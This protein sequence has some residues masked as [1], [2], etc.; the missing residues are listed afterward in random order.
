MGRKKAPELYC[1]HC[2]QCHG[3]Q[4][5]AAL[6]PSLTDAIWSLGNPTTLDLSKVIREGSPNKAMPAWGQI[7]STEEIETLANWLIT[8]AAGPVQSSTI[9]N[10]AESETQI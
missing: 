9:K 8:G 4:A 7:L 2:Q 3:A 10:S 5:K 1:Q 6:G